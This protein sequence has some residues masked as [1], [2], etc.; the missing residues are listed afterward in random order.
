MDLEHE[1]RLAEVEARSKSNSHR[2][3]AVEKD[4]EA[5]K[6][7]ATSVAV[8]AEQQKNISDKVDV[9]DRKVDTL[10]AKP[11]KMWDSVVEKAILCMI[12]ALVGFA[13]AHFGIV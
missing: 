10:E 8:M 5:L 3:D 9:I 11:G 12:A 13:M 6:S 1:R 2:L 4:Q 7:I